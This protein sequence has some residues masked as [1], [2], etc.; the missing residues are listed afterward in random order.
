M[1]AGPPGKRYIPSTEGRLLGVCIDV[2]CGRCYDGAPATQNMLSSGDLCWWQRWDLRTSEGKIS[3]SLHNSGFSSVHT[4]SQV[5]SLRGLRDDRRMS[6]R[7]D[8][9]YAA[10]RVGEAMRQRGRGARIFAWL[11]C[12]RLTDFV[13][14]AYRQVT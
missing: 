14:L 1:S 11:Y 5:C 13:T 3:T 10:A 4:A 8:T 7:R 9:G 2:G 6:F 12:S